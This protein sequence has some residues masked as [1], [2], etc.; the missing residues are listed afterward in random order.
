MHIFQTFCVSFSP[1]AWWRGEE[2]RG[3]ARQGCVNKSAEV[4][5]TA[6]PFAVVI[7]C[8]VGCPVRFQG[9][10]SVRGAPPRSQCTLSQL[11]GPTAS[12]Y[13]GKYSVH[14]VHSVHSRMLFLCF[15]F[16][17]SHDQT[18]CQGGGGRGHKVK[19]N[20]KEFRASGRA[21]KP[22]RNI[23]IVHPL[24]SL[25][26]SRYP[27]SL[28]TTTRQSHHHGKSSMLFVYHAAAPP[29]K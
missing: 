29:R 9:C 15:V 4:S 27:L 18:A 16:G 19:G 21:R 26:A 2:R 22:I 3:E 20:E 14:S 25:T 12:T 11:A 23:I 17:S 28:F 13:S 7:G 5:Q 6:C 24:S 8:I 10:V 1:A